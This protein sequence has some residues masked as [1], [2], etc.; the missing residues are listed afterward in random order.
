MVIL[1]TITLPNITVAHTH[2]YIYIYIPPYTALHLN[3]MQVAIFD[4]THLQT[5]PKTLGSKRPKP[6]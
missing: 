4:H 3:G 2:T 5:H 1:L 6:R